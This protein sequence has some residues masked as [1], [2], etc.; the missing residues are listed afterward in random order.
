[1]SHFL[2]WPKH[3]I[4]RIACPDQYNIPGLRYLDTQYLTLII[5]FFPEYIHQ[6]KYLLLTLSLHHELI[7][8]RFLKQVIVKV[9]IL[10][11]LALGSVSMFYWDYVQFLMYILTNIVK[12]VYL[13]QLLIY[14][15]L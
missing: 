11:R 14:N 8:I 6:K 2:D 3:L 5:V 1:M 4:T 13:L 7:P 9:L 15:F 12:Y 10:N